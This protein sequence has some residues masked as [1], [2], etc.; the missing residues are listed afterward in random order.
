MKKKNSIQIITAL[1]IK[2]KKINKIISLQKFFRLFYTN[3]DI[4]VLSIQKKKLY[5]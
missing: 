1:K 2:D 3:T 4:N 5:T